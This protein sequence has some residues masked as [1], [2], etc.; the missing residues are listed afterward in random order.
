MSPCPAI[1]Q[2]FRSSA[3]AHERDS[4]LRAPW[5]W[6]A[7]TN[8]YASM[9]CM[10]RSDPSH[11][12]TLSLSQPQPDRQFTLIDWFR[13][14]CDE[15]FSTSSRK[16]RTG[17]QGPSTRERVYLAIFW[18]D[19]RFFPLLGLFVCVCVRLCLREAKRIKREAKKHFKNFDGYLFPHR[20][21]FY[22]REGALHAQTNREGQAQARRR[23]G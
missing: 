12:A 6:C 19:L 21:Q 17:T 2:D 11:F 5:H 4:L 7:E 14:K 22:L 20:P 3:S 16:H 9:S 18:L 8:A 1:R 13:M 23:R 15:A 10:G